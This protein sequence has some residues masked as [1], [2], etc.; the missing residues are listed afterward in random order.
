MR[1]P[2][3]TYVAVS[4]S[5][6]FILLKIQCAGEEERSVWLIVSVVFEAFE[7]S[8]GQGSL[9]PEGRVKGEGE[10]EEEVVFE[11]EIHCFPVRVWGVLH[12]RNTE[13]TQS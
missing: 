6:L 5:T 13:G 8:Q 1:F 10:E 9:L 4:K 2:S 3:Y 12:S 11:E 7:S